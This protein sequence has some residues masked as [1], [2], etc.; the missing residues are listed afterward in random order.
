LIVEIDQAD[1]FGKPGGD[2]MALVAAIDSA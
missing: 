1:Q 2:L